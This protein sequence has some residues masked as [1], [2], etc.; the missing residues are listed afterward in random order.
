M[1]PDC[2]NEA[3]DA[4]MYSS[5]EKRKGCI[6]LKNICHLLPGLMSRPELRLPGTDI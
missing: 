1:R 3:R 4:L 2:G 5:V 6:T